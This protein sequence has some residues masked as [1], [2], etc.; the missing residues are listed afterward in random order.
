[1]V[2]TIL[3]FR[4][5]SSRPRC[6][7]ALDNGDRVQLILDADGLAIAR[8]VPSGGAN[9]TIVRAAPEQ[10]ARI[11]AG[12]V[13]PKERSAASPL[14][15]LAAVVQRIGSAGEVRSAFAAAIGE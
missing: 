10:V 11:C 6:E 7:I 15:L 4:D 14:R 12:L 9:E 8:M 5:D 13:G 3:L 2:G 1:M